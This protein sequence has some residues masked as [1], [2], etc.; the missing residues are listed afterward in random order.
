MKDNNEILKSIEF[1]KLSFAS[2]VRYKCYFNI[3]IDNKD[4]DNKSVLA[5][6]IAS[7][8]SKME[9]NPK[10]VIENFMQIEKD[11]SIL[12]NSTSRKSIRNQEKIEKN[13]ISKILDNYKKYE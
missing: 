4:I 7:H 2:L 13:N 11:L 5:K 3:Q 8:F 12:N 6:E 10:E 1:E 9:V